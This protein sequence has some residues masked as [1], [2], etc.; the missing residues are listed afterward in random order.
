MRKVYTWVFLMLT[1]SLLAIPASAHSGKTDSQ[2]G[3]NGPG[4]Y[5]YHHGYPAHDH[6]DMDGDGDIDCPYDFDNKTGANSG[7]NSVGSSTN[8]TQN[9][10]GSYAS[11]ASKKSSIDVHPA[12]WVALGALI[13][14]WAL[15]LTRQH[16]ELK[17]QEAENAAILD[18][19]GIADVKIPRGVSLMPDGTPITGA[20]SDFRPFGD[21]TVYISSKGHRYHKRVN[22]CK[23]GAAHHLFKLPPNITPCQICAKG[24]IT[25]QEVP[26]WYRQIEN[27]RK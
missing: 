23:N 15:K 21:Y 19:L 8:G 24:M 17:A 3:H 14:Y 25:S 9:D 5:H 2:G 20:V 12:F 18:N 1:L 4:G 13:G 16:K 27:K 11:S 22:C 6:W 26:M 7:S 10:Q